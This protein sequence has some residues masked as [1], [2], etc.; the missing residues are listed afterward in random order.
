MPE[1]KVINV[2]A[3][4]SDLSSVANAIRE[5]TGISDKLVWPN[6]YNAAIVNISSIEEKE[7]NFW[8]YDG[9]LL[10]SYTLEEA[11]SLTELPTLPDRTSEGLSCIGWNW[12]LEAIQAL[13]WPMDIGAVYNTTD[14]ACWLFLELTVP[15]QLTQELHFSQTQEHA[16]EI[17][18]GD[19]SELE[20]IAGTGQVVMTHT[21]SELGSYTVKI[22]APNRVCALGT[23]SD[24]SNIFGLINNTY[25]RSILKKLFIASYF[26][27]SKYCFYAC[28]G[29]EKV[30]LP[31]HA[32]LTSPV[33]QDSF[34]Y[35]TG[36]KHVVLPNA[37]YPTAP[38]AFSHCT[39]LRLICVG[40][41]V[42]NTQGSIAR[43]CAT[44][45]R[46]M[47]PD[48]C[49]IGLYDLYYTKSIL[50]ASGKTTGFNTHGC[51]SCT[52]L[53]KFYFSESSTE[54]GTSFFQD[55]LSLQEL[56]IPESITSIG[57]NCFKK[58]V[59]LLHIRFRSSTPPTVVNANAFEGISTACVIEVPM[60]SLTAY[61]EAEN[62]GNIAAQMV[63]V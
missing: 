26:Y 58:C 35:C 39:S 34:C 7:V 15:M 60:E 50:Y 10:Y 13:T 18:W 33:E 55:C 63:G 25:N 59:S 11:R 45:K 21:Y 23:N 8:D 46:Y 43:E 19:G 4:E 31:K 30:V 17:D 53:Q 36:L 20:T 62:Y 1:Y 24:T 48:N 52:S 56:D 41:L 38:W 14:G 3:F 28:Y 54:I 44:I 61:Q 16:V 6:G 27:V 12:T 40:N 5:K 32:S 37:I 49:V 22:Y 42:R 2:E 57:A 47:L 51:Y 9:T 29:L